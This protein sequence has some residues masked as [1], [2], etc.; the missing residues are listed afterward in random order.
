VLRVVLELDD[1]KMPVA[2]AH[3]L[4]LRAAAHAPHVLDRFGWHS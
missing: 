3:Q 1:V 4:S 2:G